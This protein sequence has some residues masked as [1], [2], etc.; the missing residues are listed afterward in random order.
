M[1]KNNESLKV[2][3]L[4]LHKLKGTLRFPLAECLLMNTIK[5]IRDTSCS[6]SN[7]QLHLRFP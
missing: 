4:P 5:L 6:K 1:A 2:A 3:L 7:V